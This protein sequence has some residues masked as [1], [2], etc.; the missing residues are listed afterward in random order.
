[1][2][3]AGKIALCIIIMENYRLLYI[4]IRTVR[5]TYLVTTEM[6]LLVKSDGVSFYERL[7]DYIFVNNS[8]SLLNFSLEDSLAI[9]L[10]IFSDIMDLV[11][12]L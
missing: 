7:H 12:S 2:A 6:N 4:E 11:L 10:I 9:I 8:F 5:L 1:M 3:S